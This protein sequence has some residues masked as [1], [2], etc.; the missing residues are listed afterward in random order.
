MRNG[1]NQM[2]PVGADWSGRQMDALFTYLKK[3]FGN[4]S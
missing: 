3:R 2:P 1:K 4:G